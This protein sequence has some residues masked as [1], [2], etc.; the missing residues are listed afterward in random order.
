MLIEILDPDGASPVSEGEVGELVATSLA[1]RSGNPLVRY[2]SEDL[3]R[4]STAP[5]PRAVGPAC[6]CGRS[7]EKGDEVVIDGHSVLPMDIWRA[8]ESVPESSSGYFQLIRTGRQMDVLK[9][10]VGHSAEQGGRDLTSVRDDLVGAIDAAVGIAPEVELVDNEVLLRSG[11]P[12]RSPG[13]RRRERG[14]PL[15]GAACLGRRHVGVRPLRRR[16]A[17]PP[18]FRRYA[19]R[20]GGGH[21][22]GGGPGSFPTARSSW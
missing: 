16:P 7:V 14:E 5:L 17:P 20:H 10:R 8:V 11:R 4:W 18:Q 12:T 6:G 21:D 13:W 3:V 22:S 9:V 19:A 2:R 1:P 15:E